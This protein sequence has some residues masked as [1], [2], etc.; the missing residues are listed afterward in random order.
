MGIIKPGLQVTSRQT[1]I[2]RTRAEMNIEQLQACM[3]NELN[4]TRYSGRGGER[5]IYDI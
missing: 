5:Q 1:F 4:F 3:V 2:L